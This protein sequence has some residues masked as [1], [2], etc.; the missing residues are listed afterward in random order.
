MG[1]MA[2][3]TTHA[4]VRTA[5][6]EGRPIGVFDDLISCEEAKRLTQLLETCSYTRTE[7]DREDT[8]EFLSWIGEI[9]LNT[10]RDLEI[11]HKSREVVNSG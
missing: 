3:V 11:F 10:A 1:I 8:R 2:T 6:V 9:D 4:P 7:S 5:K